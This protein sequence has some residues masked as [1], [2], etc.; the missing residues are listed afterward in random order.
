MKVTLSLGSNTD[1]QLNIRR[2]QL[3]LGDL[4]PGIVFEEEVWTAPYPTPQVPRPT[5]KYLNCF[6]VADTTLTQSELTVSLKEIER[7]IGDS[8]ENHQRGTVL[9][10]IDL[11]SYGDTV[12]KEKLW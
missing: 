4:L 6:A 2:A 10:D 1:A 5:K 9:I 7:R 12:V 11:L 8:H 3:F